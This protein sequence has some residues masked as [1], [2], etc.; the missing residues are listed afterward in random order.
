MKIVALPSFLLARGAVRARVLASG[1]FLAAPWSL[2]FGSET[3]ATSAGEP[4]AR[5]YVIFAGLDVFVEERGTRQPVIGGSETEVLVWDEGKQ[6]SIS[7]HNVAL[8]AAVEPRLTR[9]SV[10]VDGLKGYPVYSPANDPATA[11]HSQ[12]AF[13]H[14]LESARMEASEYEMRTAQ[15]VA[16][17]ASMRADPND[18]RQASMAA[19]AQ[20]AAETEIAESVSELSTT[21]Y[22]DSEIG[23]INRDAAFD[24]FAVAFLVSAPQPAND[25]Y[26]VLRLRY[27]ESSQPSALVGNAMKMFRLRKLDAKP[28]KVVI[29]QFGLPPGFVVDS[30]QI[31]IYADGRELAANTSQNRVEVTEDEAH[32]FLILRH[33]QLHATATMPAQV[34]RD[35][36]GDV[37]PV[38]ARAGL[39]SMVVDFGVA[40]DG[41]VSEVRPSAALSGASA[42][43]IMEEL[44]R[45]RFLPALDKGRPVDSHGT[46]AVGELFRSTESRQ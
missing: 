20:A 5:G 33:A 18:P 16:D 7:M 21:V 22:R 29:R 39:D 23:R 10:M 3:S 19:N 40:A 11:A 8:K 35:L 1:I 41:K 9:S 38:I 44:R 28:R 14:V 26:G 17:L 2:A 30:Y 6:E 32:Q 15:A 43:E 31:H 46:F 25:V 42:V 24:G 45:V 27:R 13:L 4:A 37:P 12:Q 34:A 36:Q